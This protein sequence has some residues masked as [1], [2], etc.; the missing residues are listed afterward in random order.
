MAIPL[1]RIFISRRDDRVLLGLGRYGVITALTLRI[2]RVDKYQRLWQNN[3]AHYLSL[4]AFI[5]A[6]V[7]HI[8]Q[9]PP[10]ARFMRGMW[11]DAGKFG[12]GQ[13]SIYVDTEATKVRRMENDTAYGVLDGIGFVAGRL[14]SAL[15]K[16]LKYVGLL[17][18][19]FPPR[20][21]TQKNAESF[22][23]RTID[24]T[25]GDPTRYLV[26]IARQSNLDEVCRRLMDVLVR[27]RK[28]TDCFSVLTLYLKG[29][30]SPQLAGPCADD[31]RWAE[32]L[33]YVAIK[34]ENMTDALLDQIV[35]EFDQT[36]VDL[37]AFRYMH[38]RTSKG[39]MRRR[40]LD[41]H[42]R[43]EDGGNGTTSPGDEITLE[44]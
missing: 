28:E 2:E 36:C 41:P 38:S 24:S 32:V 11:V 40:L 7:G 15:D 31:D 43:Y 1:V 39:P 44:R 26:A 4:D 13:W 37:D 25:V 34:P 10:E 12:L 19:V 18:I 6:A 42:T 22:S 35:D 16:A 3:G 21:A 14:P 5:K 17:G 8:R 20:Y 29:I 30:R 23:D 9:P 27:Y 33:F